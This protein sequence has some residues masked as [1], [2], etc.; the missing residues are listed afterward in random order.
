M[1]SRRPS[2]TAAQQ[3]ANLRAN[4][5][6]V[7]RGTLRAGE[8]IW[9]YTAS[10]TP[11][12]RTYELVI[13]YR[14]GGSP[15]TH[16]VA[17]D[18]VALSGGRR[19]PHVYRQKPTKLCLYRPSTGQWSPDKR[20]DQTIVP[21]AFLWLFFFEE[22]LASGEWKGGGEHPTPRAPRGSSARRRIRGAR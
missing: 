10:P 6:C 4:P 12:S 2:L 5:V 13:R 20:L 7:G 17:P 22:W 21:W 14:Q 3:Y 15:E 11:L 8:L 9:T 19:L 18:L 16:V 1:G